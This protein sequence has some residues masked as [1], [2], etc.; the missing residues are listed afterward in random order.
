MCLSC[1]HEPNQP[2]ILVCAWQLRKNLN[3][4]QWLGNAISMCLS[5]CSEHQPVACKAVK[6]AK[7]LLTKPF[8]DAD[9]I[10]RLKSTQHCHLQNMRLDSS[11]QFSALKWI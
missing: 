4:Q 5:T 7:A 8:R 2:I 1:K 10:T 6:K 11:F 9:I 3:F